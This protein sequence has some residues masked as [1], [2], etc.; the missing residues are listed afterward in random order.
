MPGPPEVIMTQPRILAFAG[1]ARRES[2]N[3]KLVRVAAEGAR[4][5]GAE[6]TLLDLR[7]LPLPLYDGDL[8]AADGL[9]PNAVELKRLMLAHQGL[10]IASPEYNSSISPLLKNAI[11]WASRPA[12]GEAPLACYVGKVAGLVSAS[13]GALGGLRG[14]VTVRSI[15]GNIRVLVVPE[16][17]AVAKAAQA[18]DEQGGLVEAPQRANVENVGAALARLLVRRGSCA[19]RQNLGKAR[20]MNYSITSSDTAYALDP[21]TPEL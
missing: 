21:A 13:P 18:F 14:L 19:P 9:P 6:V 11:D 16:Q 17:V 3:K 4:R 20:S 1:S 2:Y 12:A 8:E 5:E 7:D 15:L 10:L